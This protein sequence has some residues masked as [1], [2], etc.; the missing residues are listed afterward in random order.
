MSAAGLSLVRDDDDPAEAELNHLAFA[1]RFAYEYR[2]DC[3]FWPERGRW[4]EWLDPLQTLPNPCGWVEL[5]K[6]LSTMAF[7]IGGCVEKASDRSKWLR[8]GH[9]RDALT[10]AAERLAHD[11]WDHDDDLLGLPHGFAVNL[12]TGQRDFQKREDHLTLHAGCDIAAQVAPEWSRF[13]LQTCGGDQEMA[14]ALQVAVGA[15]AFGN[16]RHHRV[17][18]LCGDGGTGKSTFG[19][20]I[21]A[22]LGSYAGAMPASVLN[23]RSDQHPTGIAGLVGKR[24]VTVPEAA[25]G[26]FRGETL[27]ALS[28]GDEIAARFMRR[29]FFTFRPTCTLWLMTNEP[30]AVRLVDEA[31]RRRIRIWPFEAKPAAPDT[32]LPERLRSTKVLGGVLRWI[33][34]GAARAAKLAGQFPDCQAVRDAT[35]MY[36]QVADTIGAW[37]SARCTLSTTQQTPARE[38]FASY[39]QWCEAEGL[40]AAS[41]TAWGTWMGRKVPKGRTGNTRFYE[42][43]MTGMT[44]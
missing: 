7:I 29:D 43:A 8:V 14:E 31:L 27:K 16:N 26:M 5:K 36:F 25:G 38:L 24:L 19:A 42:V 35:A 1:E 34:D 41:R 37:F 21:S 10:L 39:R 40:R 13:V 15:S 44:G 28:G 32:K 18:V 11:K 4:M 12:R 6:P 2:G 33:V 22:A 3:L 9:F 17:E 20:T 23:A 30:P